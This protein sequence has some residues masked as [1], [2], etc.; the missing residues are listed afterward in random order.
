MSL[1]VTYIGLDVFKKRVKRL[2]HQ[3][4]KIRRNTLNDMAFVA[5]REIQKDLGN[6]FTLRNS[7]TA[8]SIAVN[9]A[10]ESRGSFAAVGS[11]QNYMRTQEYGGNQ[12]I[13]NIPTTD[14]RVNKAAT[15]MVRANLRLSKMG[16]L[17][18]KTGT[19]REAY[20]AIQQARRRKQKLVVLEVNGRK[21]IYQL[22]NTR[23]PKGKSASGDIRLIH[24]LSRKSVNI[25]AVD[26]LSKPL[27]K[28]RRVGFRL[29]ARNFNNFMKK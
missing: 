18:K 11:M 4:P 19:N 17:T 13:K 12:S 16:S 25:T 22:N 14:A 21:G 1:K 24:D 15:K 6:Q 7:F 29:F 5:R 27:E 26:W 9:K 2:E 28:A 3:Y 23:S 10:S 8:G 20:I